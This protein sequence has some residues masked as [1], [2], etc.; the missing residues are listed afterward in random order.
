MAT[1]KGNL[2]S[3]FA[4]CLFFGPRVPHYFHRGGIQTVAG[5][6]GATRTCPVHGSRRLVT[7]ECDGCLASLLLQLG[8]HVEHGV[9]QG[10]LSGLVVGNGGDAA[11]RLGLDSSLLKPTLVCR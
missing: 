2:S 9:L 11:L 6:V 7:R 4:L 1:V 3:D 8:G 10:R 5:R